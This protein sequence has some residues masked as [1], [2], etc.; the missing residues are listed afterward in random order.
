MNAA[1]DVQESWTR[2]ILARS[3]NPGIVIRVREVDKKSAGTRVN[4]NGAR[5]YARDTEMKR[6]RRPG[7]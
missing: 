6:E 1:V 3:A 7:S 5:L 2:R 4:V